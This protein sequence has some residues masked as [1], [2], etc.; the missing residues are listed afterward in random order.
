[1][2]NNFRLMI[3]FTKNPTRVGELI[4]DGISLRC[5][6]MKIRLA[7]KNGSKERILT[8]QNVFYFS[9]SSSNFVNLGF[10]NNAEIYY[11]NKN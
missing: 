2:F 1:M 8:L 5:R 3:E 10:L 11:N 7:K 6:T 4:S 9:N